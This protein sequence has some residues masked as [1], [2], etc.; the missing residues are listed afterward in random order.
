M[1]A[2]W[3]TQWADQLADVADAIIQTLPNSRESDTIRNFLSKTSNILRNR[4]VKA[5]FQAILRILPYIQ[6]I[7]SN[8]KNFSKIR[9]SINTLTVSISRQLL[10]S[11]HLRRQLELSMKAIKRNM[12]ELQTKMNKLIT[13]LDTILDTATHTGQSLSWW[14]GVKLSFEI[15]RITALADSCHRLL[16][17]A[18]IQLDKLTEDV[19]GKRNGARA[20]FYVCVLAGIGE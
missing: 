18:K 17:V 9:S 5:G 20:L 2:H 8:A 1:A 7:L 4:D 6:R 13:I 19:N 11:E 16:I 12:I 10:V 14:Q 3:A 15:N